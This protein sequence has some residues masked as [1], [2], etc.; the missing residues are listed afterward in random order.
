MKTKISFSLDAEIIDELESY[1]DGK[2]IRS[3]SHAAETFLR[4]S[5]NL[6]GIRQGVIIAGGKGTRLLPLTK[7]LPKPMIPIQGKPIVEHVIDL[8]R[9][10]GI[11]FILMIVSYKSEK[12][13]SY[14]GDGSEF[15]VKIKYIIEDEPMGTAG[16]LRLAKDHLKGSFVFSHCDELKDINIRSIAKMHKHSGSVATIALTTVQDTSAYGVVELSG[17]R[18][19]NFVEKPPIEEAPSR[20]INAGLTIFDRTIFDYLPTEGYAMLE[21]D[22]YPKLA[23]QGLVSG[24]P[25]HGQWYDT[26]T[27]ERYEEALSNWKGYKYATGNGKSQLNSAALNGNTRDTISS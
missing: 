17:D 13:I 2:N 16:C 18:I 9:M 5:L 6:E 21:Q 20:L 15:G 7:E 19:V 3:M 22:V 4:K 11:Y 14:F 27:F 12:I 23:K 26:G 25:F 24:Y 10:N 8:Y 1:V